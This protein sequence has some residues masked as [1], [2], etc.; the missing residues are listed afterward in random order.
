M[1]SA[2]EY[3]TFL[4]PL[5]SDFDFELLDNRAGATSTNGQQRPLST[6]TPTV[7]A[8]Q[9][10]KIET[11]E[12]LLERVQSMAAKTQIHATKVT[13][14]STANRRQQRVIPSAKKNTQRRKLVQQ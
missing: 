14:I 13:G 10:K 2:D 3:D 6:S 8:C 12:K 7:A 5:P 9:P 11:D 4:Q 1:D